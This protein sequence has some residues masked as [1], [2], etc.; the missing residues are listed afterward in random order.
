MKIVKLLG[1]FA[2]ILGAV[3]A[4]LNWPHIDDTGGPYIDHNNPLK[5]LNDEVESKWKE[6]TDWNA[7]FYNTYFNK[8]KMMGNKYN[9]NTLR[10]YHTSQAITIIHKKIFEQWSNPGCNNNVVKQ[11]INAL[12]VVCNSDKKGKNHSLAQEISAVYN[13][14]SKALTL[15]TSNF[16][17]ASGFNGST[18]KNFSSHANDQKE[19]VRRMLSNRTYTTYLGNINYIS[20][21]LNDAANR[22]DQARAPY[23]N[24]LANEIISYY[25][26]VPRTDANLQKLRDVRN[27]YGNEF[28]GNDSVDEF[29]SRFNREVQ[30]QAN[31]IN[32]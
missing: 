18:W 5:V 10:D 21:R 7:E 29:A 3:V 28:S 24:K 11:Y 19:A 6:Q 16:V 23:Y 9:V 13:V 22:I 31:T 30:Q 27:R 12:D 8:I 20:R 2:V 26:N 17:P 1:I 14:Y 32:F 4:I 25:T 15:A